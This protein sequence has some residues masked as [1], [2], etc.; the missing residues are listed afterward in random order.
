MVCLL[1]F[2]EIFVEKLKDVVGLYMNP[3]EHALLSIDEKSQ[4][5]ALDRTQPGLPMKRGRTGTMTH[6]SKRNGTTTLFAALNVLKCKVIGQCMKRH[7]HQKFLASLKTIDC[8]TPQNLSIHCIMDGTVKLT[9]KE[10]S[11]ARGLEY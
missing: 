9:F 6:D 4:I 3:P 10:H 7:R 11:K 8:N 2:A 5:Q 1:Y